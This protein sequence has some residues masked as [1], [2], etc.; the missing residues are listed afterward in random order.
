MKR[1]LVLAALFLVP[2]FSVRAQQIASSRLISMGGVSTAVS[3]NVDAIGTN[4]ANL[5]AT[6][7]GNVVVELAPISLRAG[8]DFLSL[9]L[10]NN[11]FTGTGQVDSAGNKIGKY[12][13]AADK[14]SI[15]DAFPGG[16]G[17]VL[18]DVSIRDLGLSVRNNDFALGFAIDDHVGARATV[19]NS[20]VM[21]ALD[22]NAPGSNFS[23]DNISSKA[24]WY[25][26]Y[27]ADF[28]IRLPN[29]VIIPKDIANG[30]S[31]GIGVKYVTGLA[32]ASAQTNNSYLQT[33]S[34]N[35][36]FNVGL[37]FSG[38]RAG[39]L[40]NAI[41]KAMKSSVGDTTTNVNPFSP[42]G[43]GFG[44]DLGGTARV[45]GFI[46]VGMS[47]TDIGAIS[48]TKN[49]ISTSGDTSFTFNGFSP[50]ETGVP[51][52]TSNL[53]SLNNAFKNFFKNRDSLSSGFTTPLPTRFNLGASV[54]MDEVFPSIPG[55][56]LL[57]VDYHQGLNNSLGNSTVP[58]IDLGAEWKP[59]G[60]LPI[61]T[62]LGFGG[63]Y[64][65]RWALGIGIDMPFWDIDLGVGTFNDLVAPTS[66]KNL[67]VTLSFLKFRF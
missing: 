8:T 34:A 2:L 33:D 12:L 58:E 9:N 25:R 47:L 19:P 43:S 14:Q 22:G 63:A 21:F 40:S 55:Q 66:A 16:I 42:A 36:A 11:Y 15:L 31:A 18:T 3:S 61:R 20:F 65:F 17:T 29:P 32:Y 45:L 35:Y 39:I 64:G 44:F 6:S 41:S 59:I 37:G 57:A 24:W 30:F 7:R 5:I 13:T 51:N 62:G 27:N 10:Y 50:A 46:K 28:A 60:V 49:T 26:S 1:I 52:A 48:W 23:W 56:L 38:Q 54:N 4:P 53:D 67:S